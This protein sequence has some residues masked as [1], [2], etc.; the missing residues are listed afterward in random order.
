M[1]ADLL[2][3]AFVLTATLAVV[4]LTRLIVERRSVLFLL[5]LVTWLSWS[6]LIGHLHCGGRTPLEVLFGI[7]CR[8]YGRAQ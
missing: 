7:D 2:F 8:W 3:V 5:V 6:L 4:F 1:H